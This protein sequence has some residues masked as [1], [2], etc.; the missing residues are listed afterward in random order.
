MFLIAFYQATIIQKVRGLLAVLN[1]EQH[2]QAYLHELSKKRSCI[3]YCLV[4]N[5][6]LVK[7]GTNVNYTVLVHAW[8]ED[9]QYCILCL[10]GYLVTIIFY[11]KDVK[12]IFKVD[13]IEGQFFGHHLINE[14]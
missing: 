11:L 6:T 2:T 8:Y 12:D 9:P 4:V 3:K 14:C 5:C 13:K 10:N 7:Q 1:S